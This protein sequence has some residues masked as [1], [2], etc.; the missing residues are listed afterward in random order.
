MLHQ[1]EG[2]LEFAFALSDAL[3]AAGFSIVQHAGGGGLK[4]QM[5]KADASGAAL[6]LIVGEDE[7]RAGE[8]TVKPLR[9][10]RAQVRVARSALARRMPE[11]L[12]GD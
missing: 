10:G 5:K 4:A 1:G 8:V 12:K 2:T 7:L 9:H 11:F 3:R 6:A